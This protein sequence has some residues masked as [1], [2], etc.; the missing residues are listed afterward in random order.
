MFLTDKP[1][2]NAGVIETI[3][4]RNETEVLRDQ[5]WVGF[6]LLLCVL[7]MLFFILVVAYLARMDIADWKRINEFWILWFNTAL[8]FLSGIAMSR[9]QEA[10]EQ[11]NLA[12]VKTAF[13]KA[14]LLAFAFLFGQAIVWQ[15]YYSMGYFLASN[16]ANTFFYMVT[17]FHGLHLLVGLLVWWHTSHQLMRGVIE[18]RLYLKVSICATYW[19]FLLLVWLGLFALLLFT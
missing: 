18:S 15:H 9:V 17:A 5:A 8:L 13:I 10:I 6:K 7:T 1:W 2:L 11:N 12:L 19:H 4:N 3:D 16:P 14:G